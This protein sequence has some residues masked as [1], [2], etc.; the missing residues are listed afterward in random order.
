[1]AKM[2]WLRLETRIREALDGYERDLLASPLLLEDAATARAALF[3]I[4]EI[5]GEETGRGYPLERIAK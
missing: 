4:A 1:M 3:L 5:I 2:Q